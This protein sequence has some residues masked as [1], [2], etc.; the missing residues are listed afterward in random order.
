MQRPSL[1]RRREPPTYATD[2][3]DLCRFHTTIGNSLLTLAPFYE[4]SSTLYIILAPASQVH[5]QLS[6]F[7]NLRQ[8]QPHP[9][10]N[11][12]GKSEAVHNTD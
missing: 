11:S 9:A 12:V 8:T 4:A 6:P 2:S 3:T 10:P 5:G 7:P 1:H